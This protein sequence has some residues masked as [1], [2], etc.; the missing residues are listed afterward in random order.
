MKCQDI[1]NKLYSFLK[2]TDEHGNISTTWLKIISVSSIVMVIGIISAICYM[3]AMNSKGHYIPTRA[4]PVTLSEKYDS[5]MCEIQAMDSVAEINNTSPALINKVIANQKFIIKQQNELLL[6]I[7]QETNN[8]IDKLT[9]WLSFWIAL[10]AALGVL[11]P[12][13]AEYRFSKSNEQEMKSIRSEAETIKD[14]FKKESSIYREDMDNAKKFLKELKFHEQINSLS[15]AWEDNIIDTFPNGQ[16]ILR[17]ILRDLRQGLW[18]YYNDKSLIEDPT[19]CKDTLLHILIR[20]YDF[21]C[22]ESNTI[23]KM[24]STRV[25]DNTKDELRKAI[26]LTLNPSSDTSEDLKL[27]LKKII[28]D[29][30]SLFGN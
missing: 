6:D 8:N 11:I 9:L 28:K 22:R 18:E 2:M 10:I 24:G 17:T 19:K 16:E 13:L 27:S 29:M 26:Q 20:I 4:V 5:I 30:K 14:D 12:A 15:A 25:I 23:H 1:I 21:M 7:R 3:F